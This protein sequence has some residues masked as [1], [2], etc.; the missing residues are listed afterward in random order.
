LIPNYLSRVGAGRGG[1]AAAALVPS[2]GGSVGAA[3]A[4]G[5]GYRSVAASVLQ[6]RVGGGI[7]PRAMGPRGPSGAGVDGVKGPRKKRYGDLAREQG[8]ADTE[9]IESAYS[10]DYYMNHDNNFF[11]VNSWVNLLLCS[12]VLGLF[13]GGPLLCARLSVNDL[14]H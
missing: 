6:N 11:W 13:C 4:V 1:P 3:A 10:F 9:L 5:G 8:W 2:R 12:T 14:R 7:A